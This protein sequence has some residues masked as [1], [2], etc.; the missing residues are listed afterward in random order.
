MRRFLLFI[1]LAFSSL[2]EHSRFPGPL[3]AQNQQNASAVPFQMPLKPKSVRFAAIGDT[4]TGKREQYEV[5]EQMERSRQ[6][7]PF[8]FV[9]MLGDNVYGGETAADFKLK[10]EDPYKAMLDAGVKFYASLGNHDNPNERFYKPF[11][12]GG[13]RYYSF[14]NANVAFFALDSNYMDPEQ[15]SWLQQQLSSSSSDWKICF[16]H[17]PL[18]SD[19]RFH[20][21]DVDLRARIAPILESSG[22]NVVL[23]G[24]DHVYE[25]IVPQHG[26]SY[27]VLGNSGQLRFHDLRPSSQMIKGYDED[28]GFALFEIAGDELYFQI[29]SRKGKTIDSGVIPR[30]ANPSSAFF[31]PPTRQHMSTP[32]LGGAS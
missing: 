23:S 29:I 16:F 30:K 24:H 11:N 19:G 6:R 27:F 13:K 22:V 7:F 14:K 4:G 21:A 31:Q 26:I 2:I 18:R 20:G 8:E 3:L 9:V 12:M 25:R 15:V 1:A 32:L 10:F 28:R 5:A 17:H